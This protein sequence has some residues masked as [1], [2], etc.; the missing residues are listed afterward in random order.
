MRAMLLCLTLLAIS[1][2]LSWG[3]GNPVSNGSFETST[4]SGASAPGW[5]F[6]GN[7]RVMPTDTPDGKHALRLVREPG[8]TGEVGLNRG[9]SPSSGKQGDMLSLRKGAIRFWYKAVSADPPDALSVQVIPMSDKPLE[10]GQAGRTTWKAPSKHVGDG[11]WHQGIMAYD[12]TDEPDVKWVHV[13]SRLRGESGELWLDGIEWVSEAGPVFQSAGLTF[14]ET[15]GREGEEGTL[16][17]ELANVGDRATQPGSVTLGLPEGLSV[18]KTT[19]AVAAIPPGESESLEWAVKGKRNTPGQKLTITAK[20]GDQ[21][22]EDDFVLAAKPSVARLSCARMILRAGEP[23]QVQLIA[24][25]DGHVTVPAPHASLNLPQGIR[26]TASTEQPLLP[27]GLESVAQSWTVVAE[28]PTLLTTLSASLEGVSG[29][30]VLPL[31]IAERMPGDLMADTPGPVYSGVVDEMAYIGTNRVRLLIS[32]EGGG[33][34]MGAFQVKRGAIWETAGILPRLGLIASGDDEVPLAAKRA[35]A[36]WWPNRARLLLSTEATINRA[37]WRVS[38]T[39]SALPGGDTIGFETVARPLDDTTLAALEGPMLYCGEAG[40]PEREDAILP[41]L[42]WLVKGEESSNALDILPQHPDRIRYVPHPYK[43]CV[44]AVG[45]RFGDTA[46]GLLWDAP[47]D[48][49]SYAQAGAAS[50]VFATPNRFEG[51][52]NH[53]MG[54]F[55]PGVDKGVP[56]NERRASEPLRV[57]ATHPIKLRASLYASTGASDCLVALDRW[58]ELNGYP[59]PLPYPRGGLTDEVAFSMQGYFK[60]HALWNPEWG[61]WYSDLIVGFRPT[62]SP[63]TELLWGAR[64]LGESPVTKTARSLAAEVLGGDERALELRLEHPSHPANVLNVARQVRSL[65]ASQHE[66]GTW[67]FGGGKAGDWPEEGVNYKVL[68][69]IGASEVGLSASNAETVLDFALMTGDPEATQAGLK[70]LEAMRAFRVPRAAQVWEVPVH[71]PDILASA[72]AVD[73][74]LAGY[75][76][77]GDESWLADAVYWA[78]TGLPFVYVW[79]P[80]DQPAMQGASIPV[81]GATGYGL[82]WFAVAVQWNG[83][84]YA[85]S[86]YDLAEFDDSFPWV[87][88]A[89]NLLVSGMY[90]QATE[91]PRFAQWPDALNFIKGRKG[92]HGQTPPCFQPSTIL[93]LSLRKLGQKIAPESVAVRQGDTHLCVRGMARLTEAR[94]AGDVLEFTADFAP[95]QWGAISILPIDKPL[96]VMVDGEDIPWLE[97]LYAQETAGWSWHEETGMAQVR[98][99]NSGSYRI[100]VDGVERREVQW[101]PPVRTSLDFDFAKGL[102]GW[103]ADHDLEPLRIDQGRIATITTG[104]DPYMSR[105]SLMVEGKKGD[106]LVV[107]MSVLSG[108]NV[109]SLF[110]STETKPGFAPEREVH[111]PLHSDGAMRDVRIPIGNHESW[112]NNRIT[113]VRIDPGGGAVGSKVLIESM[114]LDRAD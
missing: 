63:A 54:L 45:M 56:E 87:R 69:P 100:R 57:K 76:L 65:I 98:L 84:A 70:A 13:S 58:Y 88:V 73:A 49:P 79:Q 22:V 27:P 34:A 46:V 108:G 91:P 20:A 72:R 61:K 5:E 35:E 74:Y 112:A 60:E 9:W 6:L 102:Q 106:V 83:L 107:R 8:T 59:E 94:W 15:R 53:L 92:A 85:Q 32:R 105:G 77:T 104:T 30:A 4:A 80:G 67:R 55:L 96:S 21:Q 43:V 110:W 97:D 86:L 50:L 26:A 7:V 41:G 31:V 47:M 52:Q 99:A 81:F 11:L 1:F 16:K 75:R 24:A 28:K 2:G 113:A 103:S 33:Y 37:R 114:R 68:G 93:R 66:D 17:L 62:D 38:W 19:M 82:S 25:N 51:H 78:R 12:Y 71:T 3:Q 48:Q 95:G 39:L 29:T 36:Q 89:D 18:E 111:Y 44:P 42:E 14:E 101:A 109:G 40:G 64:V 23:V 10:V 90:Q